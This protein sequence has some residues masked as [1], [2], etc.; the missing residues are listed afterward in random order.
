MSIL[1]DKSFW[2]KSEVRFEPRIKYAAHNRTGSEF[3]KFPCRPPTVTFNGNQL[4]SVGRDP[5]GSTDISALKTFIFCISCRE[6]IND[7]DCY[8][9]KRSGRV[10]GGGEP[11]AGQGTREWFQLRALVVT[12]S[13]LAQLCLASR[14]EEHQVKSAPFLSTRLALWQ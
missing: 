3:R 5:F 9:C 11:S 13:P 7:T 8:T 10:G 1:Y 14:G 12:H 4:N 6:R 2:R